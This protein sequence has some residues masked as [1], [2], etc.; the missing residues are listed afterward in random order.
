ME[1]VRI[2]GPLGEDLEVHPKTFE[3]IYKGKGFRRA[4]EAVASVGEA[5][6]EVNGEEANS[7]AEV[8]DDNGSAGSDSAGSDGGGDGKADADAGGGGKPAGPSKAK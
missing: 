8:T 2:Q 4:G 6:S 5:A 1:L 7:E 3:V